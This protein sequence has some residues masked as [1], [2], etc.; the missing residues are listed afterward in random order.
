[1]VEDV[2]FTDI[3]DCRCDAD[4]H[5][6]VSLFG[7]LTLEEFVQFGIEDAVRNELSTLRDG[8]TLSYRCH[9]CGVAGD[10]WEGNSW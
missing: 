5:T 8:T 4:F 2:G 9:V 1:M 3:S 6:R 10:S 7:Q